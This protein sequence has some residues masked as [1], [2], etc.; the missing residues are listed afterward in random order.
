MVL[1]IWPNTGTQ[2]SEVVAQAKTRCSPGL[3][4]EDVRCVHSAVSCARESK[5]TGG[6]LGFPQASRAFAGSSNDSHLD[7]RHAF[8]TE[9]AHLEPAY[10]QK[11]QAVHVDLALLCLAGY[12]FRSS[13]RKH[14]RPQACPQDRIRAE[15][16]FAR[17]KS[18]HL[19]DRLGETL[20]G[21]AWRCI[22]LRI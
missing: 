4:G 16:E 8:K 1:Q 9:V 13:L 20:W 17:G 22:L 3:P 19:L 21:A 14:I 6:S 10:P 18:W 12:T 11:P 2:S 15:G 7:S 5:L